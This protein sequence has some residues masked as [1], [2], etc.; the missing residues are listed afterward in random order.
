MKNRQSRD[1]VKLK[2]A[3]KEETIKFKKTGNNQYT[4]NFKYDALAPVMISIFTCV[5]DS[6]EMIHYITQG[7]N[8]DSSKGWEEHFVCKQGD[9]VQH[10]VKSVRVAADDDYMFPSNLNKIK[11]EKY[12]FI[13]RMVKETQLR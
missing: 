5:E 7:M 1:Y 2:F 12:P 4:L 6:K 11:D 10:Q 9:A 8:V 13:V 3:L